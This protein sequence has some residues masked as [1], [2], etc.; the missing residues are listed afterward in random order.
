MSRMRRALALLVACCLAGCGGGVETYMP[1]RQDLS[2]TYQVRSGFV[3][4][5]E[6]ATAHRPTA[7]AEE[8]GFRIAGPL[9]ASQLAWVDG[10]L[11]ASECAGT[12]FSPP[13]ALLWPESKKVRSWKGLVTRAGRTQSATASSQMTDEK[14]DIFGRKTPTLKTTIV[15]QMGAD[16]YQLDTWFVRE[17]GIVR[18]EERKNDELVRS[19]EHVAGP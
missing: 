12:R 11:L 18:Q 3:S 4:Y 6:S 2:W 19:L 5:V 15:M 17:V 9:G 7:V 16:E 14:V 8:P 13:L 10:E 1:L